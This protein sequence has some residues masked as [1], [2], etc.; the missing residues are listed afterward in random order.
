MSCCQVV[1]DLNELKGSGTAMMMSSREFKGT[2]AK[3]STM[4]PSTWLK[5]ISVAFD[6][7][8]GNDYDL[9]GWDDHIEM[10]KKM[11]R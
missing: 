8:D 6:V 4:V 5:V 3:L 11:P 9:I 7:V 1:C 10:V 2:S